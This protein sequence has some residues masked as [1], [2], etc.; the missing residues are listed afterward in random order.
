MARKGKIDNLTDNTFF[1]FHLNWIQFDDQ[2]ERSGILLSFPALIRRVLLGV[3]LPSILSL[4]RE[5]E[6]CIRGAGC[7]VLILMLHIY[8]ITRKASRREPFFFFSIV[9]TSDKIYVS[10]IYSFA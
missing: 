7:L 2:D 5:L 8:M 10:P 3:S 4:L 1:V 9:C 6:T